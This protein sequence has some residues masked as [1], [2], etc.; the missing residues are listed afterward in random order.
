[1]AELVY[2]G[3]ENFTDKFDVKIIAWTKFVN[4]LWETDE[5]KKII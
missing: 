3:T 5:Q 1:M 2:S 4:N